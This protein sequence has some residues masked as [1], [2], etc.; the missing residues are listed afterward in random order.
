MPGRT[1]VRNSAR[2]SATMRPVSRIFSRS[3]FDLIM[4]AIQVS[5]MIAHGARQIGPLRVLLPVGFY[6]IQECHLN[7]VDA[8]VAIDFGQFML[9][10][11]VVEQLHGL[12]EKD[13]QA[14]LYRL[15]GIIRALVQLTSIQITYAGHLW[16]A[17]LYVINVLVG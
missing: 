3:S 16:R 4:G 2:M 12:V 15:S 14:F 5:L 8:L 17:R 6:R 1:A 10:T 9:L 13:V 7:L 11:I